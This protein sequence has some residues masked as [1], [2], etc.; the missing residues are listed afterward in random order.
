MNKKKLGC[1]DEIYEFTQYTNELRFG[2]DCAY[3][4]LQVQG[5]TNLDI[6]FGFVLCKKKLM[7]G[8]DKNFKSVGGGYTVPYAW[9]VWNEDDNTIY[10]SCSAF[11][12][13]GFDTSKVQ[14][15]LVVDGPN[16][17]TVKEFDK[18]VEK[19]AKSMI[20]K[21]SPDMVYIQGIAVEQ[22]DYEWSVV[23][24]DFF[25]SKL[26]FIDQ[27]HNITGFTETNI[28]KSFGW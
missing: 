28:V 1:I 7:N 26:D 21:G 27:N 25:N 8:L 14:S 24:E 18:W 2:S 3:R 11:S 22:S 23:R 16:I 6:N 20:M 10:D 12:R 13:W 19:L 17:K 4:A 15:V 5:K 9:H